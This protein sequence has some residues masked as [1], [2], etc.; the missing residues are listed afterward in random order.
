M[1]YLK[2][3][4]IEQSAERLE[5]ERLLSNNDLMILN[6]WQHAKERGYVLPEFTV[7]DPKNEYGPNIKLDIKEQSIIV[8]RGPRDWVLVSGLPF[9]AR[10]RIALSSSSLA[11]LAQWKQRVQQER[12]ERARVILPPLSA[13]GQK[14]ISEKEAIKV[15]GSEHVY[16]AEKVE[17]LFGPNFVDSHKIPL[18]PYTEEDLKSRERQ[19]GIREMLILHVS[20]ID[21]QLL[22]AARIGELVQ[23]T[24]DKENFS[25]FFS[26][27]GFSQFREENFFARDGLRYE[28]RLM[29]EGFIAGSRGKPHHPLS[30]KGQKNQEDAIAEYARQVGVGREKIRRARPCEFVYALALHDLT[31]GKKKE[32]VQN[33]NSLLGHLDSHW[34]DAQD[35]RGNYVCI[36]GTE[37]TRG[38]MIGAHPPSVTINTLG[39]CVI[40]EP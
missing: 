35:Q 2:N 9:D 24:C 18:I 36:S 15:L 1:L 6:I 29:T 13:E 12:G 25:R 16:G 14:G 39:V 11:L 10:E 28:W 37:P 32:R 33:L 7:T 26:E 19:T 23:R 5:R 3:M 21:D 27:R 38:I 22:T 30:K 20:D 40:R 31:A 4:G 8:Q 17:E 34:S